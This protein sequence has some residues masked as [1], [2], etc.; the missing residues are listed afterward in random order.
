STLD[1]RFGT[2]SCRPQ[3]V[4]ASIGHAGNDVWLAHGN[5]CQVC[6]KRRKNLGSARQLPQPPLRSIQSEWHDTRN[7]SG[8]LAYFGGDLPLCV[9]GLI[10]QQNFIFVTEISTMRMA[11]ES[12]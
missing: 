6:T 5:D 9:E 10:F 4:A 7:S 8:R 12:G 11:K 2:L 1:H 3:V